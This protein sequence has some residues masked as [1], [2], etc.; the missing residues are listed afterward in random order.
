MSRPPRSAYDQTLGLAFFA[1]TLDK[2]RLHAAGEL[3]ADYQANLGQGADARLCRFLRV[4][5]DKLRERVLAGG[6]D[7]EILEW[8]FE[9]GR[10]LSEEDRL[11]YTKF[12]EKLG[13]RDE[14]NGATQR[15]E[16]FKADA[17]LSHRNDILTIFD[18]FDVDEGRKP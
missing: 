4:E 3:P 15:Q 17:G 8:C 10:R 11:I 9:N 1:R 5:Y 18:F 7:E 12:C 16:K 2:I 6:T 14:D 13:W